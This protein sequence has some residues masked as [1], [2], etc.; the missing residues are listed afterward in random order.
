ML[1]KTS[2]TLPVKTVVSPFPV[3]LGAAGFVFQFHC[4]ASIHFWNSYDPT[5]S[6]PPILQGGECCLVEKVLNFLKEPDDIQSK[7]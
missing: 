1:Q 5:G 2:Q 4:P 6:L 3:V 7:V